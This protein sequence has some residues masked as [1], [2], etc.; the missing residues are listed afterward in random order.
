MVKLCSFRGMVEWWS[1]V[2]SCRLCRIVKSSNS[3]MVIE[4]SSGGMVEL[5]NRRKVELCSCQIVESS[6]GVM[7]V[8]ELSSRRMVELWS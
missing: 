6:N 7:V 4:S 1:C 5:S 2:Y 8:V 3:G